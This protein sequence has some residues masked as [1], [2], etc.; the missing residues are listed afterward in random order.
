[1]IT[2][3]S[4]Y[5]T[6]N[7]NPV[8]IRRIFSAHQ[9]RFDFHRNFRHE[10][11]ALGHTVHMIVPDYPGSSSDESDICGCLPANCPLTLKTG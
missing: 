3:Y 1:M 10:L 11:R 5:D 7:E 4:H 8:H 2:I 9:R 6:R